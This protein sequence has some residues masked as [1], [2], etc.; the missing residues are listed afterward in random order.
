[1]ITPEVRIVII[2]G[3]SGSGKTQLIK[4]ICE[5]K[6]NDIHLSVSCTTRA[7]R[8]GEVDGRDYHF[9]T[10]ERF[11]ELIAQDAFLEWVAYAGEFYGTLRKEVVPGRVTLLELELNGARKI[12]K[13]YPNTPLV[14][15]M[16]PSLKNLQE[17]ISHRGK[18]PRKKLRT[19]MERAKEDLR[20]GP[21]LADFV[22][23]NRDGLRGFA[24]AFM[25][26]NYVLSL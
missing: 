2:S 23:L 15:I 25:Q 6:R 13:I 20:E 1:M 3:S 24:R 10:H 26:L 5:E 19:R 4:K 7:P 9:V 11:K 17:R 14:F 18:V 22:I 12:K 8:D 21:M 16:A